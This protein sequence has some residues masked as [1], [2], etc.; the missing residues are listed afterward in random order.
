MRHGLFPE[1]DISERNSTESRNGL[2]FEGLRLRT[3]RK[4]YS[5]L[6]RNSLLNP[7]SSDHRHWPL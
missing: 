3:Y 6:K 5:S 2:N 1:N 4:M 7:K